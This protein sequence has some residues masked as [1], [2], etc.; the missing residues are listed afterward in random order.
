MERCPNC[1][2]LARPGAKFCTTCGYRLTGSVGDTVSATPDAA[3]A[4]TSGAETASDQPLDAALDPPDESPP[5]PSDDLL[6]APPA[7]PDDLPTSVDTP[8][9]ETPG[10]ETAGADQVLSSSWPE[11]PA[12][13]WSSSWS[14]PSPDDPDAVSATPLDADE[15]VAGSTSDP[16]PEEPA[17][18]D[19]GAVSSD[20][21]GTLPPPVPLDDQ[22][23]PSSIPDAWAMPP[24]HDE[25]SSPVADARR[26]IEQLHALLP[27]LT[28]SS[29]DFDLEPVA[30]DL[31]TALD[32]LTIADSDDQPGLRAA[33][34]A[35]RERPRDID[36]MLELSSRAGS[37]LTLLD[38]H[39][40][41]ATTL[42]RAIAAL[43]GGQPN[44]S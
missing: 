42:E 23:L 27:S 12:S 24:T 22:T 25:P 7:P 30:A 4:E 10:G 35:A 8:S 37:L 28:A 11:P 39:D 33:L 14:S 38:A 3:P 43:R 6:A 5:A 19:D 34:Q 1:D 31:Q 36:V 21:D 17:I 41:V 29:P 2:A 16:T 9:A 20:V 18:A 13:S 44:E 15:P 32:D 40:R 26:L